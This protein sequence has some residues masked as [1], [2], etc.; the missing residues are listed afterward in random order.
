[1]CLTTSAS[2]SSLVLNSWALCP[3]HIISTQ[4]PIPSNGGQWA[5]LTYF[6]HLPHPTPIISTH[7]HT[8]LYRGIYDCTYASL[9]P[10]GILASILLISC[11]ANPVTVLLCLGREIPE[12]PMGPWKSVIGADVEGFRSRAVGFSTGGEAILSVQWQVYVG[13]GERRGRGFL[14]PQRVRYLSDGSSAALQL[15]HIVE[16]HTRGSFTPAAILAGERKSGGDGQER[17][18]NRFSGYC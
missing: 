16:A 7:I 4:L 18:F 5:I 11:G 15:L 3:N 6:L 10:S 8:Q 17:L 14:P 1:M 13:G 9:C 12:G 2:N